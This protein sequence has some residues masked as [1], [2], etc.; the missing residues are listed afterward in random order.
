MSTITV[1]QVGQALLRVPSARKTIWKYPIETTDQ[2]ELL[3]PSGAVILAVQT[4]AGAPCLWAM[5][6]PGQPAE[7][8]GITTYGTGHPCYSE[9]EHYVG[10][11]QLADGGLVFHV[12][13]QRLDP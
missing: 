13:A 10:T 8:W 4:Q 12:F 9:A 1:E 6:R 7:R 5:V 11:Y 2:Q 3:L